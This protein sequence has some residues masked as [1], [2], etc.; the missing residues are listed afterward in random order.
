MSFEGEESTNE[1][2]GRFDSGKVYGSGLRA[3]IVS[4]CRSGKGENI[5]KD[6]SIVGTVID[7][8]T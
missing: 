2:L 3:I 4:K 5:S 8:D 7:H 1:L 6:T